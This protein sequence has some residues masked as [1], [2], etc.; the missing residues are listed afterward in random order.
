MVIKATILEVL[1]DNYQGGA[2]MPIKRDIL[3]E[4]SDDIKLINIEEE[5]FQ[6]ALKQSSNTMWG[7]SFDKNPHLRLIKI[8]I[9]PKA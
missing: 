4:I 2:G 3:V 8:E 5:V 7:N 6:K 1:Q 9:L